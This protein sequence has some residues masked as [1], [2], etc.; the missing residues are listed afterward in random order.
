[1]GLA[2]LAKLTATD[3]W[4]DTDVRVKVSRG[5]VYRMMALSVVAAP[6]NTLMKVWVQRQTARIKA[7]GYAASSET[8]SEAEARNQ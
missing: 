5:W 7:S 1:M 4:L 3:R 8:N 6:S 2:T